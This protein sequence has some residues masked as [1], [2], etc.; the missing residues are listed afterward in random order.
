M[1]DFDYDVLQ[2]KRVS[3]GAKHKKV[4]R[5][6]CTL[7]SDHLTESEKKARTGDVKTYDLNRPMGWEAFKALPKDLAQ[8]YIQSLQSRFNVGLATISTELF[9]VN[10]MTLRSHLVSAEIPFSAPRRGG[11]LCAEDR[12]RWD[13]FLGSAWT[14][15]VPGPGDGDEPETRVETA[16][17]TVEAE[18]DKKNET[19]CLGSLTAEFTG[20]FDPAGFVRF[21]ARMP[22]PEGRV[23]IR[24]EVDALE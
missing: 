15:P 4:R 1:N 16:V 12:Y 19:F 8:S 9:G 17:E 23:H 21:L 11:P 3:Y 2:K 13:V 22:V 10:R 6:G 24:L 14:G 5:A 7:P 18:D 20:D